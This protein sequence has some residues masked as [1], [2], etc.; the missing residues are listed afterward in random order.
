MKKTAIIPFLLFLAACGGGEKPTDK[1]TQLAEL[2]KQQ[3]ELNDKITKLEAETGTKDSGRVAEV[4]AL[5]LEPKTFTSYVQVQGSVDAEDNTLASPQSAG[6]IT[7]IYV[8]AGQKV[9]RGQILARLDAQALGQQIAQAQTQVNL[10]QTLFQ[11]Q[12][13]LWDQKIGTEVQFLQA[14]SNLESAQKQ[15]SALRA[16]ADMFTIKSP[17][18]GTVDQMDL[19]IGQSVQP[20]TGIRIVN[21]SN[22]KVKADIAESYAGKISTGDRVIV[23]FPDSRDSVITK[24][25]FASSAIDPNSRNFRVEVKLPERK[26]IR[27]NMTAILR[28]VD[29]TKKNSIVIPVKSIQRTEDG[30]FVYV[31]ENGKAKQVDIKTGATYNGSTEITSGLKS[32]D[33]VVIDGAQD[34]EAGD[35]VKLIN[36]VE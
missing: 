27:P 4:S 2:K 16:Q 6:T 7:K 29:Y 18:S 8:K 17:T 25:T 33:K 22:L 24:V 20:G 10:M 32:G 30:T 19:K 1:K 23:S 14:K 34:I 5:T 36:G 3:S 15:L 31:A 28:I 12:K 35:Q 26:T 9:S 21:L 13:N 11:R